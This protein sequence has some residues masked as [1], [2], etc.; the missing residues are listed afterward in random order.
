[1][2]EKAINDLIDEY[3]KR[4]SKYTKL[5]ITEVSDES[6]SSSFSLAE[7][8]NIKTIEG[9]KIL[10]KLAKNPKSYVIALDPNGK[11]YDSIEFSNKIQDIFVNFSSSITYIIGGS[12]GLS[13]EVLSVANEKISFS[14]L[15]F[16]HKL[17]RVILL[18]Q[19]Y[20]A[21]KIAKGETYHK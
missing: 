6:L 15:T 16:P 13:N 5:T 7:E 21:F 4:L 10:D 14:K 18:E 3:T 8:E 9:R 19:I 11:E 12:I 2:K 17:F 1:M 20:R